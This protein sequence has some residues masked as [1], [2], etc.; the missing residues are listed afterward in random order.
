[1]ASNL[2]VTTGD[3]HEANLTVEI[4]A[5]KAYPHIL[6]PTGWSLFVTIREGVPLQFTH[7]IDG[8]V[9]RH[10]SPEIVRNR[11]FVE[12]VIG[13]KKDYLILSNIGFLSVHHIYTVFR[14]VVIIAAL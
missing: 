4:G 14:I 10:R 7:I 2:I 3:D 8:E 6:L 12:R 11:A 5:D 1:M 13:A 9:G